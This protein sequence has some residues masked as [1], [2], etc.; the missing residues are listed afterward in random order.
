M[1]FDFSTQ[2]GSQKFIGFII[3]AVL[4]GLAAFGVSQAKLEAFQSIATIA[5]PIFAYGLFV[6]ANQFAAWGKAKVEIKKTEIAADLAK[7]G[8]SVTSTNGTTPK[9]ETPAQG[10]VNT[11]DVPVRLPPIADTVPPFTIDD[12]KYLNDAQRDAI[13]EIYGWQNSKKPIVPDVSK[14]APNAQ[15]EA[16]NTIGEQATA[17]FKG[18][19]DRIT[20]LKDKCS[21][22]NWHCVNEHVKNA[23]HWWI[24]YG[25]ALWAYK[26]GIALI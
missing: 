8:I 16:Q 7:N 20:A 15:I 22:E 4:T 21:V 9:V 26:E 12:A 11:P 1:N 2:A 5:L 19:L 25:L 6:V 24:D 10:E 3:T 13:I 17:L 18:V 23:M 14:S